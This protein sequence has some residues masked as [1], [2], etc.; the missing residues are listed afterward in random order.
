M[1]APM[2]LDGARVVCVASIGENHRHT[3]LTRHFKH[4]SLQDAAAHLAICRYDDDPD[5]GFY[6]FGCDGDW[7]VITDTWHELLE[8]AKRQAR[9][10]YDNLDDAW[11]SCSR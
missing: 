9:H 2:M 5:A 11:D 4:G 6:L 8:A 10:E 7:N 3:G 1:N